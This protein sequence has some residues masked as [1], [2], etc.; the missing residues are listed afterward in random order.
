MSSKLTSRVQYY[1]RKYCFNAFW[2]LSVVQTI[3]CFDK[4]VVKITPNAHQM[5]ISR[6]TGT[7]EPKMLSQLQIWLHQIT[8]PKN[9]TFSW[10]LMSFCVISDLVT[11]NHPLQESDLLIDNLDIF[12]DS[13]FGYLQ[14]PPPPQNKTFSWTTLQDSKCILEGYA[15]LKFFFRCRAAMGFL[16]RH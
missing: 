14:S 15:S 9:W 6:T 8:P 10:V 12:W 3:G 5:F 16:L 7:S 2:S 1:H 4:N 13:R 11:T